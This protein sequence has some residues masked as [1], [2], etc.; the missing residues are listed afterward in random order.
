MIKTCHHSRYSLFNILGSFHC[1]TVEKENYLLAQIIMVSVDSTMS[2]TTN[3]QLKQ[4]ESSC[5]A[6]SKKYSF[7]VKCLTR[8]TDHLLV[9]V[10]KFF[11][12]KTKKPRAIR[13]LL[14]KHTKHWVR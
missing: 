13:K 3:K 6:A 9:N 14:R 5:L 7:K 4:K 1:D 10:V 2:L 12:S 11:E 8:L